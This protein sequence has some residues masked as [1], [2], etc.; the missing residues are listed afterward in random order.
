MPI[1]L[2]HTGDIPESGWDDWFAVAACVSGLPGGK[3]TAG[4]LA[5]AYD[6]ILP[7]WWRLAAVL[8]Q[9]PSAIL[10]H[11]CTAGGNV[12]D[13]GLM[14]AWSRLVGCWAGGSDSILCLCDDP[15]MFRHLSALPGVQAGKP[16]PLAGPEFRLKVRGWLARVRVA[17]RMMWSAWRGRRASRAVPRGIRTMLVYGHPAS[18]P[19]GFDAYFGDLA[20]TIPGLGRILHVDCP[21]VRAAKLGVALHG[22]GSVAAALTLV[23][24]RWRPRVSGSLSWLVRRAAALEGAT[25]TPAMIA[26]QIHCQ[27]RFL[28]AVRPALVAWPWENHA[29]ERALVRAARIVGTATLGYQHATIGTLETN[30]AVH[31]LPDGPAALPDCIA[32]AGPAG[33]DRLLAWGIPAER[34]WLGGAWRFPT[35]SPLPWNADGPVFLPLPAQAEVARQMLAAARMAVEQGWRFLVRE[36]PLAPVGFRPAPGLGLSPGPLA[37]AGP[38]HAVVFAG[39]SVGL[40]AVL[41]GL[42]VIRFLPMGVLA[43]DVLPQGTEMPVATITDLSNRLAEVSGPSAAMASTVF[44]PIDVDAWRRHIGG[45]P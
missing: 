9:E 11:A 41:S 42:P 35:I 43:N 30:Y 18:R 37:Q 17:V 8:G 22:W 32:C 19:D 4:A 2:R 39:S 13:L 23:F 3:Q 28:A 21:P 29:W 36:H 31:S 1:L 12:S 24:R 27:Q 26:W 33:R 40:E 44:A 38:L 16:P 14:L 34:L 25:G 45:T 15:W 5:Q 7:E 6:A 10:S 20:S